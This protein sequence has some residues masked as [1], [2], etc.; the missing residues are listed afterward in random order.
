MTPTTN[1]TPDTQALAPAP[2]TQNLGEL[3]PA[4]RRYARSLTGDADQAE[5]LVQDSLERALSRIHL[6]QEG[7]NLRRWVF[8]ILHNRFCDIARRNR[9]QGRAIPIHEWDGDVAIGPRQSERMEVLDL[10]KA[11]NRLPETD[12]KVI[13]LAAL[14]GLSHEETA[15]ALGVAIGTVKSR[16]FRARERF[17]NSIDMVAQPQSIAA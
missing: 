10:Q 15:Q 8:T 3:I 14:D 1:S 9:R 12:R 5:D 16:L 13:Q 17:R 2:E 11:L 6:Y 7:T 4:L